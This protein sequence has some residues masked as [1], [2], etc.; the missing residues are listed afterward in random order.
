MLARFDFPLYMM[1]FL[2]KANNLN[3]FLMKRT[4]LRVFA[5]LEDSHHVHRVFGVV[6]ELSL[7]VT[8]FFISSNGV[9][10]MKCIYCGT[11]KRGKLA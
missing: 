11:H 7:P 9:K 6:V 3:N 5:N 10:Q 2:S 8:R 1:M 4:M